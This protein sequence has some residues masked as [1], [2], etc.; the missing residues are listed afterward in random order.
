VI[1]PPPEF[2]A[3]IAEREIEFDPGDVERLGRFLALLLD[4]NTRFNL[5]GVTDPAAA[6]TRHV[7]DSLTLMPV[8][9]SLDVRRVIDVGSGGGLPGLPLALVMPDV[10]FT[11]LEATGKKAAFLSE[12]AE[13][14][15]ATNVRVVN[16]RA[17]TVG[18]DRENHREQYDAVTAR[19]VGPLRVLLELTL[20]LARIDGHV[21]AVKGERAADEIEASAAALHALHAGVVSAER[22]PTGTI[23]LIEKKRR[24]PKIYPRRPGEPKRTPL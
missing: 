9:A 20:P 15:G 10:E 13:A 19:A 1:P 12:T 18:R 14:L 5:T 2:L 6:W 24:T 21:L 3:M 4:A 8:L 17:E 11:L 7:F 23:V 22:T 16:D